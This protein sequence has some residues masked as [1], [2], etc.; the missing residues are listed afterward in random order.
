MVPH[1]RVAIALGVLLA[2][3]LVVPA[4]A[5]ESSLTKED[6]EDLAWFDTLGFRSSAGR[7]FVRLTR[8]E[9]EP[10]KDREPYFTEGFL[11]QESPET[12]ALAATGLHPFSFQRRDDDCTMEKAPADLGKAASDCL[13]SLREAIRSRSRGGVLPGF[14]RLCDGR[15]GWLDTPVQ[16][17]VLARRCAENGLEGPAA[18]LLATVR[19]YRADDLF[20]KSTKTLREHAAE[21]FAEALGSLIVRDHGDP[22]FTRPRLLLRYDEWLRLFPGSSLRSEVEADRKILKEMIA[23]DAAHAAVPDDRLASLPVDQRVREL[24]FRLRDK[25][26]QQSSDPGMPSIYGDFFFGGDNP[27][28]KTTAGR[29]EA[30]G[31]DAVP[32]LIEALED[33]RFTRTLGCHRTW[34]FR[35]Y[36]VV[37]IGDAAREIL[38]NITGQHFW[39]RINTNGAMIKDGQAKEVKERY[40][41]WWKARPRP[42]AGQ[43]R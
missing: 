43:G 18:E 10:L 13:A 29:I 28:E 21:E 34:S 39:N 9:R 23:E 3:L 16:A 17:F 19:T 7:P 20:E 24:L 27:R 38:E 41:A 32:V 33:A 8:K 15:E 42:P 30:I 6:R 2:G 1:R 22:E 40:L 4:T 36:Y 5:Q 14:D 26:G 25:V 11:F 31:I 12:F 35:S 37:R